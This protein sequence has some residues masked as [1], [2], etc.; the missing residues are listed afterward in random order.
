MKLE[1]LIRTLNDA[2]IE[3]V[4]IDYEIKEIETL[5]IDDNI[6]TISITVRKDN[7]EWTVHANWQKAKR[8]RNDRRHDRRNKG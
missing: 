3:G 6:E 5:K 4:P 1:K 7:D 8:A 2:V